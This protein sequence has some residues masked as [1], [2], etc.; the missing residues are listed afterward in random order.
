MYRRRG[1][2]I[3]SEAREVVRRVI[4]VC[5]REFAN[6]RILF[7]LHEGTRRAANYTGFSER[8]ISRIRRECNKTEEKKSPTSGEQQTPP[9]PTDSEVWDNCDTR[10]VR[11]AL[12]DFY[13]VHNVIP[14]SS[15]LLAG[16]NGKTSVSWGINTLRNMLKDMGFKWKKI[17]SKGKIL[18]ERPQIS[19]W[20]L[21]YL[22]SIRKAREDKKNII[23]VGDTWVDNKL[24][25]KKCWHS[26]EWMV[27]QASRLVIL[28]ACTEN[29]FVENV[30]YIFKV[31]QTTPYKGQLNYENFKKWLTEKFLPNIQ[32]NSVIVLDGSETYHTN[33]QNKVP[34]KYATKTDLIA[35]LEK[36]SVPFSARMCKVELLD[37]INK[38][39]GDKKVYCIDELLKLKG[40][41]VLR[42]PPYMC[43]LNPLHLASKK[44]EIILAEK[45]KTVSLSLTANDNHKAIIVEAMSSIAD[46]DWKSFYSY[47]VKRE[48][49]Y[50]EL[51][52]TLDTEMEKIIANLENCDSMCSASE[53]GSELSSDE[54]EWPP[55]EM[56]ECGEDPTEE[57][58]HAR[59][60]SILESILETPRTTTNRNVNR[61][62][63]EKKRP[64]QHDDNEKQ[65][66]GVS[67]DTK[68]LSSTDATRLKT[69]MQQLLHKKLRIDQQNEASVAGGSTSVGVQT[70]PD[71]SGS[72]QQFCEVLI[73]EEVSLVDTPQARSDFGNVD[74][75]TIVIKQ[76]NP[77]FPDDY[78]PLDTSNLG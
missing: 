23:Y 33:E 52:K 70:P 72:L 53:S 34:S 30:E 76:E 66:N 57:H 73:K 5:D 12:M 77:D 74:E 42:L 75:H 27:L 62:P 36:N 32:Q 15:R 50:W 20:R 7:S 24:N 4:E 9:V 19:L 26:C 44:L 49:H 17:D 46:T 56:V 6:G 1:K 54:E 10:T 68:H 37:L 31:G 28:H 16:I 22:K 13:L 55:F 63:K 64:L 65:T 18:M 43:E 58:P 69:E 41:T 11:N 61:T 14:T 51:D 38:Y 71:I 59:P 29:G 78:N 40:H 47:V 3:Q 45:R 35:W 21:E 39:K 25:V 2:T 60:H 8:T 48:E 67:S